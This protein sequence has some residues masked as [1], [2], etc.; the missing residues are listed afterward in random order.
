MKLKVG[1]IVARLS[2]NCDLLFR[3]Q[4][5]S[6]DIVELVGEEMR[7]WADAPLNDLVLISEE[8]RTKR[9]EKAL[10][11]ELNSYRL[12]RQDAKLMKE[13]NEYESTSGYEAEA[14]FFE[15]RGRVLHLDGDPLYLRKCTELYERLGVPVYGVHVPEKEMPAQIGSLL[16]MVQ[17]DILVVTGHDA[18]L[19]GKGDENDLR[20]Y[21][22]TKQFAECVRIAR[23]HVAH[24]DE[25][26]IFAGACQSHF[27]TLIRAGANFASSP[28]RVNIHA[29]DP[30]YIAAR[31]SLTSFMD[32]IGLWDVLR[33][34]ITGEK[35]L[36]GIE[37]RGV[38]RR[39]MP[40]KQEYQP[41]E[42]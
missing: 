2:Y 6:G 20:S 19:K 10:E 1:D 4:K 22:H 35:G 23:K 40:T 7:L 12:F 28:E 3:V 38:M 21:R 17:P 14:T 37:T 11:K 18:F 5:I 26:V 29:L 41:E 27:E 16:E 24:R 34:T 15:M 13:R 32:R 25:L 33:N 9:R 31:V 42:G 36:G 8:E 30:V 39:G